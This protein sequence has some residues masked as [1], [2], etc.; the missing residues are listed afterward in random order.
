[1]QSLEA[2]YPTLL[3]N[4]CHHENVADRRSDTDRDDRVIGAIVQGLECEVA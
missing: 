2:E 3:G 1:V 4:L